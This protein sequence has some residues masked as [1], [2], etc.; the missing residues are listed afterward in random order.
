MNISPRTG[1]LLERTTQ[2]QRRARLQFLRLSKRDSLFP[3]VGA[4]Y[5]YDDENSGMRDD[6]NV[7]AGENL[8]RLPIRIERTVTRSARRGI[9]RRYLNCQLSPCGHDDEQK[10]EKYQVK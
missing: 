5:E 7:N 2:C 10:N 8:E 4:D 6:I 3:E 9:G 1:L